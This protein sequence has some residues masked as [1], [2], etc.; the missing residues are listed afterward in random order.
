MKKIVISFM[1]LAS[2][3][4]SAV[5]AAAA[6]E[7]ETWYVSARGG[8]NCRACPSETAAVLTTYPRNAELQIIGVDSS[9]A[10]Y[11]SWD[12]TVQGWVH[13]AYLADKPSSSTYL[14]RFWVTGYTT[15]P[16]ENGGG[17]VNC[18]G[19]PL[20][21]LVGRIIA[22]DPS[23]IPL[24]TNIRIDGIGSFE[25][26]DTGVIGN[27]IDVLVSSDDEASALTGWYDVWE[28]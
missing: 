2:M 3:A 12:G 14:G 7:W 24:K 15:D 17:T 8:L 19:E 5:Y 27:V 1:L 10:W 25:T 20:A 28:D 9:G 16:S 6:S 23:V 13:S 11:E 4:V 18:F 21:P 22:V 26:R